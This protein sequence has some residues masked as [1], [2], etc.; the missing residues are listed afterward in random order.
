MKREKIIAKLGLE[1]VQSNQARAFLMNALFIYDDIKLIGTLNKCNI[2]TSNLLKK[3]VRV[4]S[5]RQ[6]YKNKIE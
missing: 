6:S 4:S 1:Y 3:Q 2:L 5:D